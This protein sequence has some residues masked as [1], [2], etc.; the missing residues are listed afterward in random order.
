MGIGCLSERVE[1]EK[2]GFVA[3]NENEFKDYI[4]QLFNNNETW[5]YFR[6]NLLN[7]RGKNNWRNVANT[8][9]KKINE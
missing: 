8:F 5:N 1:H 2:T 9:I 6:N 3:K 4:I 7:L